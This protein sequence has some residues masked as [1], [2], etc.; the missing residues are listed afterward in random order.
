MNVALSTSVIQRGHTGIA[1]YVF[2]LVRALLAE[3]GNLSLHL[4]VLEED[5]PLFAFARGAARITTVPEAFRPAIRD[6]A[7]HQLALPRLA[8][9]SGWDVLHVPS[10]RRLVWA[11]ACP[12]TGTVHDLAPFRVPGKY[13]PARMAYG[14][15]VVRHLARRQRMLIAISK[16]TAE[17]I[18]EFFRVPPG[19]IRVVP[20]GVDRARFS[21][22]DTQAARADIAT[23]FGLERPFL[24]YLA[25]LEHPG[26][27]HVRLIR[28]YDRFRRS[29][30]RECLLALCGADW[31][32]ADAIRA[33][34]A[35]SR[36]SADIRFPGFVPAEVLP[37]LYR[38]AL[39][40]VCPS[41]YEGFG[42][43][44]VE[45]MACGC[46]VVSST[47]GA[48]GEVLGE[49]AVTVDPEDEGSM[50]EALSRIVADRELRESC[51]SRGFTN[52][53]RFS[54]EHCARETA[55][56]WRSALAGR[57]PDSRQSPP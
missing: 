42:L 51:V 16:N 21:P 47:R 19:R 31:T 12:T 48:L 27:N 26:K 6:I 14:R 7:W 40:F 55:E 41:L 50:A 4:L 17:D 43:P 54:W 30:G 5:L 37:D 11:R 2:S 36:F 18:H 9:R 34:A 10:Y 23:R 49:A 32:G 1:Q 44:P 3:P 33:A 57:A 56:V 20:N 52:A 22:G 15:L 8:R 35:G 38:A 39:A 25:R 53:Q 24:L 46:P 28:A 45:A 29:T 13:D